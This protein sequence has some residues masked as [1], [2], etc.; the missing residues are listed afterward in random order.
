[1]TGEISML[2]DTVHKHRRLF[3]AAAF[4]IA[5]IMILM[6]L[7]G[8]P[9]EKLSIHENN[10]TTTSTDELD[11]TPAGENNHTI[12]LP[13]VSGLNM[14]A[15]Q[16]KQTVDFYNPNKNCH[17]IISLYLSDG[18]LIYKSDMIAPAERIT[19]I[20]LLQTLQRGIYG[21]CK[22]VFDCL[23]LDKKTALNGGSANIEINSR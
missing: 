21:K 23:A 6:L 19:E 13:I 18:T 16:L 1:M 15:G 3:V 10:N 11:F 12:Q 20:T 8:C 7:Y 4:I 5:A 14:R 17:F 9:F 22:I 2:K